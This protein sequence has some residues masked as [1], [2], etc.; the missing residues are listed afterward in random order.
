M[1]EDDFG[2]Y[3]EVGKVAAPIA[4]LDLPDEDEFGAIPEDNPSKVGLISFT[5]PLPQKEEKIIL[6]SMKPSILAPQMF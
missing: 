1:F 4:E 6:P 5:E 2:E 3:Q